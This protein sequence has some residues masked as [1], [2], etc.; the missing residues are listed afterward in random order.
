M[1]S[2]LIFA[3]ST[4]AII[5]IVVWSLVIIVSLIVEAETSELVAI[6]FG[7]GAIPSLFLAAFE[8][9]VYIQLLVFV[10]VS[11][12]LVLVTRKLAKR[13]SDPTTK[14]N[15]EGMIDRIVVVKQT[16]PSM[17]KGSVVVGNQE[18]TAISD[19]LVDIAEGSKVIIRSIQGNKLSVTKVEDIE[20]EN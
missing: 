16:I 13:I 15:A 11:L 7:V 5:A 4:T 20:I 8:I 3:L 9:K 17:G 10:I 6:W 19:S 18:W 14:T 2:N 1:T 12:T